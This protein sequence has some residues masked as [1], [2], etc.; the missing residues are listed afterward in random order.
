[1]ANYANLMQDVEIDTS[2]E[3]VSLL[4]KRPDLLIDDNIAFG[5]NVFVCRSDK[6]VNDDFLIQ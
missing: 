5:R 1:M 2:F 3:M 4:G 6:S